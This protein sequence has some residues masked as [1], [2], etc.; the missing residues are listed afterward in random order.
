M[1][2]DV[3]SYATQAGG[4]PE[5]DALL[6]PAS[7]RFYGEGYKG[8]S[9]AIDELRFAPDQ[10]SAVARVAVGNEEGS[11]YPDDLGGKYRPSVSILDAIIAQSQITQALLYRM[12]GLAREE[13]NTLWMRRVALNVRTPYRPSSLAFDAESRV[14]KTQL[15][16]LNGGTFR[17]TDFSGIFQG[18]Q[19]R[20]S[21]AHELPLRLSAH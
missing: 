5:M 2:H 4:L 11:P 8:Q 10:L 17:T 1:E 12:D 20:Y 7:N 3:A 13:T 21:L 14:E 18:V 19:L 9:H 15:M 6:G 16:A